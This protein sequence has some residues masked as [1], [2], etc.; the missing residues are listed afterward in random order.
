MIK[1]V[2]IVSIIF[3]LFLCINYGC[4]RLQSTA[5]DQKINKEEI[6]RYL[7]GIWTGEIKG[8]RP[9]FNID[10]RVTIEIV[11]YQTSIHGIMRTSDG[12]IKND[13]LKNGLFFDPEIT[14]E[15]EQT[16]Y[17]TETILSFTGSYES[18]TLHG[19]WYSTQ[20]DSGTWYVVKK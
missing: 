4:E 20:N 5:P 7:S 6:A 12:A 3:L 1:P 19:I 13:S 9:Y 17:Y 8:T 16:D 15:A 14:F 2:R 18:N 10:L 11:Q